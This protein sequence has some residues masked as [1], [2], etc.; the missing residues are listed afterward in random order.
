MKTIVNA[1][2]TANYRDPAGTVF[3]T[4]STYGRG[5]EVM[6]GTSARR[7]LLPRLTPVPRKKPTAFGG[8]LRKAHQ[9][10]RRA[11][12]AKGG[13]PAIAVRPSDASQ[14]GSPPLTVT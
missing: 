7:R 14:C 13:P 10:G 6:M 9:G 8:R 11:R 5:V 2:G 4:Y 12:R 3:H 1:S